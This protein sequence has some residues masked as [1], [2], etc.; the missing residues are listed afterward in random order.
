MFLC[1]KLIADYGA[2]RFF[3][4][5]AH[6]L[7][8]DDS[9]YAH[10]LCSKEYKWTEAEVNESG[11]V[12]EEKTNLWLIEDLSFTYRLKTIHCL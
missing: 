12:L 6:I 10:M 9:G 5:N 7:I 11:K 4:N 8:V 3:M 2:E 1:K